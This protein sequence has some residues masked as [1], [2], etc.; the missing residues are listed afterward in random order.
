[1][2][3]FKIVQLFCTIFLN[4]AIGLDIRYILDSFQEEKMVKLHKGG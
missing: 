2:E 4:L 1:M 3:K